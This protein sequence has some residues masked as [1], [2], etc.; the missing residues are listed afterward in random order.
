MPQM[1]PEMNQLL[2]R[3]AEDAA[4]KAARTVMESVLVTLGIDAKNPLEIQKDMAALRDMRELLTDEQFRADMAHVRKWREAM[5]SAKSRSFLAV[6]GII[7]SGLVSAI[8]IG[9]KELFK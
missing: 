4:S 3:M 1:Q 8:Y 2:E 7:T 9:A 6:V 5:D